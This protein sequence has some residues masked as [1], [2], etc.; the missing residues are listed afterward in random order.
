MMWGGEG[1]RK[2]QCGVRGLIFQNSRQG[3]PH[4]EGDT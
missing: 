2:S 4:R 1:D 3:M